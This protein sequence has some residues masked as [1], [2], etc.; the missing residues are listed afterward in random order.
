MSAVSETIVREFFEL[1]CFLVR[2]HR[3]YVAPTRREDEEIDFFVLNPRFRKSDSPLPFILESIDLQGVARAVV[4]VKGWHTETFSTAVIENSPEIFRFVEPQIFQ[5]AVKTF[6]GDGPLTK[7]LVVPA[8][9]QNASARQQSVDLLRG[10]GID[11]VIPFRTILADLIERTETNR[12]Y[13]KSDVL[14]MIRI[15]KNYE[16]FKEPQMELFKAKRQRKKESPATS[17]SSAVAGNGST[18]GP[19]N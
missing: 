19:A 11:G 7:I 1:H 5:H 10:K 17:E 4:G 14:Q 9:P 16:F 18:T 3:K 8:L 15:L 6:E 12:N 13:Q 2:Q